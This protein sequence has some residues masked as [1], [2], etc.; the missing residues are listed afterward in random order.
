MSDMARALVAAEIG[1]DLVLTSY[2]GAK[3]RL[4]FAQPFLELPASPVT[5]VQCVRVGP[6]VID[7]TEYDVHRFGIQKA[8]GWWP[9]GVVITVD[10][11]TGWALD[12]EPQAFKQALQLTDSHLATSPETGIVEV[13]IGDQTVKR[14]ASN[15]SIPVQA[16]GLVR[17]WRKP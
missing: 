16:A 9:T 8:D 2:V 10:F 14:V 17:A 15:G 4:R 12:E 11:Q 5:S 7:A 13:R 3:V 1:G 6:V